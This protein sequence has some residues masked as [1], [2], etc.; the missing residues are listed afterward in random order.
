MLDRMTF[1]VSLPSGATNVSASEFGTLYLYEGD[2]I[3]GTPIAS[4][5]YVG[6]SGN[7]YVQFVNPGMMTVPKDTIKSLTLA[8]TING[9]GTMTP[10]RVE[11]F[12]VG[13]DSDTTYMQIRKSSGGLLADADINV[14]SATAGTSDTGATSTFYLFHNAAPVL[15][16][17]ALSSTF[18][19]S[20]E[21]PIF[22]F[23]ISNPGDRDLRLSTTTIKVNATGLTSNGTT[24]T[25]TIGTWKLWEADGAG[26][27][28]TMLAST[29][30][31]TIGGGTVPGSCNY[32][33]NTLSVQFDQVNQASNLLN[34]YVVPA[35][36]SRTWVVTANT[37]N[38]SNGGS[39]SRTVTISGML[40]GATGYSYGDATNEDNW[41]N[42]V[43]LY[44]YIPV[45][46]SENTTAYS[47]SD[48]YDVIGTS[49]SRSF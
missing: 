31:C 39:G 37:T 19:L 11:A 20:A 34:N 18:N 28:Q 14:G 36:S 12:F 35:G 45:G 6:G 29:S 48:S 2:A 23:T 16:N 32:T 5:N 25:G 7:G 46:G 9:S 40:D 43:M 49:V 15:A 17:S 33:N 1:Y 44:H 22:R 42:G 24:A 47:A 10:A 38:V 41:A 3:T 26:N 8:G 30:T 21:E 4:G 27:K 13:T